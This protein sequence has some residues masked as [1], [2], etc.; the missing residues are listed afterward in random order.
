MTD[1]QTKAGRSWLQLVVVVVVVAMGVALLNGRHDDLPVSAPTATATSAATRTIVPTP[2]GTPAPD[3]E[4]AFT[5]GRY[6]RLGSFRDKARADAAAGELQRKGVDAQV[7]SSDTVRGT[8]PGSSLV[9]AGPLAGK[10]ER[11]RLVLA[12]KRAGVG[13]VPVKTLAPVRYSVEP[14]DLAGE[15]S[16][17]ARRFNAKV[18]R[19]PL[20][21]SLIN[22]GELGTITY[23]RPN[24]QGT[25][26]F[27]SQNGA[28]AS[29]DESIDSGPCTPGGTWSFK[30][31]DGHLHATWSKPG[32]QTFIVADLKP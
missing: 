21:V 32:D 8:A 19:I 4:P 24:C 29:Y 3:L 26:S 30:R 27:A 31:E 15:Y 28:V 17:T 18:K 9:V 14:A 2:A 10:R 5:A 20:T 22:T 12:A 6:A 1:R 11:R 25:L 16:D 23:G 7:I 13:D